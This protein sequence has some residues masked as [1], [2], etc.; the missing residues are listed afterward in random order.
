MNTETH[1]QVS[2]LNPFA[3]L[4]SESSLICLFVCFFLIVTIVFI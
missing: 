3:Q 4:G 2:V 1:V